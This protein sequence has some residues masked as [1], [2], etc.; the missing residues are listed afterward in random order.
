MRSDTFS[1]SYIC[2]HSRYK[3]LDHVWSP[4][5]PTRVYID[6]LQQVS[7]IR[8]ASSERLVTAAHCLKPSSVSLR[9]A[10]AKSAKNISS[11]PAYTLTH[12]LK[13]GS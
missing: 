2:R 10:L 11:E 4:L 7:R 6:T 12:F 5:H 1:T 3:I 8:V 9:N 13:A